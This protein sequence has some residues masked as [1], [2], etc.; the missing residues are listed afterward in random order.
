MPCEDEET[1]DYG[2]TGTTCGT[3]VKAAIS[4][5]SSH[6]KTR[7]GHY[8]FTVWRQDVVS[9]EHSGPVQRGDSG[10]QYSGQ[11]RYVFGFGYAE[12]TSRADKHA[13]S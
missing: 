5:S 2:A 8:L 3:S 1:K 11:A 9:L 6:A 7:H 12:S 10:L 4:C 13:A